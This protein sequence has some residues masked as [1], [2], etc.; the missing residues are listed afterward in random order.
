MTDGM[1]KQDGTKYSN[2]GCRG[3]EREEGREGMS[4]GEVRRGGKGKGRERGKKMH[5]C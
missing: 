4:G 5:S 2:A 1:P 3:Q